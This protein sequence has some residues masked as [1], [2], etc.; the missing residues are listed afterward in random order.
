MTKRA[1]NLYPRV[2]F[3]SPASQPPSVRHSAS[4]AGPAAR[5]IAPSTPP[6]PR[7]VVFAAFTI[8]STSNLVMSPRTISILVLEFFILRR[9]PFD[10]PMAV[11]LSRVTKPIMQ[12]IRASLPEFHCV[13]PDSIP[14]PMRWQRDGIVAEAFRHLRHA[15]VQYTPSI[16]HLALARGPRPE[17]TSDRTG[18][19][20]NLRFFARSSFHFPADANLPVQFDPIESHRRI[21]I[22][23]EL[24]S[25][26]A[27]VVAK[28]DKPVLIE[29]F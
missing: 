20:I 23:I 6:P 16:E 19:K 17:L 10:K 27:F 28:K 9:E 24:L 25:L 29:T 3:A 7:S 21:R 15:R 8:A 22:G 2:I 26:A 5:W 12:P 4:S 11:R 13:R 18:M 1:G 14:A